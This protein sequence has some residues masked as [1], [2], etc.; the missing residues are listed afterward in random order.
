MF[1]RFS[2]D[3]QVKIRPEVSETEKMSKYAEEDI[4]GVE[5]Y[6]DS[7]ASNDSGG[8]ATGKG[9]YLCTFSHMS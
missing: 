9:T 6:L 8:N 2:L 1:N 7:V 4:I 5:D 3:F